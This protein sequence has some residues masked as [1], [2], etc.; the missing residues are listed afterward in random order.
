MWLQGLLVT[1]LNHVSET[2]GVGVVLSFLFLED[3][4]D[5]DDDDGVSRHYSL[6][7]TVKVFR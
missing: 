3:G 5:D 4:D 7:N 2:C 1:V 6:L